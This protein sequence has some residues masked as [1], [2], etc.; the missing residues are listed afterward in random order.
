MSIFVH[1]VHLLYKRGSVL[2][3]NLA[4]FS[5]CIEKNLAVLKKIPI[6]AMLYKHVSIV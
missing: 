6:F 5:G 1:F 3:A 2:L 4:L